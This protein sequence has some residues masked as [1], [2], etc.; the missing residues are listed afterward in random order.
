MAFAHLPGPSPIST[1]SIGACRAE[2]CADKVT[3]RPHVVTQVTER[4]AVLAACRHLQRW[5]DVDV[6]YL[7]VDRFGRLDPA[8]I[9]AI[10]PIR[11]W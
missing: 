10:T 1:R 8:D 4:P 2:A 7:P 3:G 5:H 9:A 6:T 11:C